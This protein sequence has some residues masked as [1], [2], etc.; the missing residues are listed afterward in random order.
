M[1]LIT[2]LS[3]AACQFT[4]VGTGWSPYNCTYRM[5]NSGFYC[6]Q[7]SDGIPWG[8][9]GNTWEE[10]VSYTAAPL[11]DGQEFAGW[12]TCDYDYTTVNQ[13]P[14]NINQCNTLVTRDATL[15]FDQHASLLRGTY[16]LAVAKWYVPGDPTVTFDADGQNAYVEPEHA[17]TATRRCKLGDQI[18]LPNASRYPRANWIFAGWYTLEGDRIGDAGAYYTP[19]GNITLYAHWDRQT[20]HQMTILQTPAWA[21]SA[22]WRYIE[23]ADRRPPSGNDPGAIGKL[24]WRIV[25]PADPKTY[26]GGIFFDIWGGGGNIG[27]YPGGSTSWGNAAGDPPPQVLEGEFEVPYRWSDYPDVVNLDGMAVSYAV[28]YRQSHAF[29]YCDGVV[30]SPLGYNGNDALIFGGKAYIPAGLT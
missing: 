15:S 4:A 18:T 17:A 1:A 29:L 10:G 5:G 13:H 26:F 25:L 2:P 14:T 20:E 16:R 19:T 12:Y 30:G 27:T 23:Y 24:L 21:T 3:S 22:T 8:W 7:T 28:I 9:E 11:E 6:I